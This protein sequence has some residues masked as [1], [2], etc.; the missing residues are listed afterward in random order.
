V[1]G[2]GSIGRRHAQNLIEIGADVTLSDP[3]ADRAGS[4]PGARPAPGSLDALPAV[5]A[6]VVASPTSLH[7]HHAAWALERTA[8]VLVEKPLVTTEHEAAPLLGHLDRVMVGYNLRL[9]DGVRRFVELVHAGRLGRP[10]SFRL[11][12]GSWLPDWRPAV[13]YRSTYSAQR[14]LGGGVLLDAIHELD[15]LVWLA[16]DG[17]FEVVGAVVDRVGPLEIDCEDTVKAVLRHRSGTPAE[18]SLDYLARA[19][20]RGIE[21][22]GTEA[23]GRLDW[24]SAT[25]QVGTSGGEERIE[26]S[27]D[28][29]AAYKEEAA[30]FLAFAAAGGDGT[31]APPVGGAEGLASVVLADRIRAAAGRP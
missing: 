29:A 24:A 21:V 7:A 22:I 31:A 20:R 6:V 10:L 16:G 3:D 27:V 8:A 23:T 26:V 13:D 17:E 11:W 12:F 18:V 2:A 19:Y 14:A 5:D 4:V 15:L 25:I 28:A 1:I 9:V 30:R